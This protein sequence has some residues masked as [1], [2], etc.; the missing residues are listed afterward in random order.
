MCVKYT[1]L[2]KHYM[3]D[4][5][6]LLDID[7]L[8]DKSSGY[9]CLSFM[10]AY[11]GYIQIPLHFGDPEKMTFITEKE[12][13]CY[14]FMSFG[15]KNVDATYQRM[16]NKFFE[17]QIGRNLDFYVDDMIVR[18]NTLEQHIANLKK[19]PSSAVKV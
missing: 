3:K 4:S 10:D 15:L 12:N 9:R 16:M 17:N 19:N 6:P 5:Y 2:D 18:S 11:S 14:K 7:K 8:V 1:N 13:Y